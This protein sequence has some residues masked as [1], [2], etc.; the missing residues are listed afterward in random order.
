MS[1]LLVNLGR[2]L[3]RL[4][5]GAAPSLKLWSASDL[6]WAQARL[7]TLATLSP[8]GTRDCRE[9]RDRTPSW[10][11]TEIGGK[12]S[13]LLSFTFCHRLEENARANVGLLACDGI[14]SAG[15]ERTYQLKVITIARFLPGTTLDGSGE[16]IVFFM[17]CPGSEFY[18]ITLSDTN[19]K[20]I[21]QKSIRF[22]LAL[23]DVDIAFE[24]RLFLKNRQLVLWS[25]KMITPRHHWRFRGRSSTLCRQAT[26]ASTK[27]RGQQE[28]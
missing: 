14:G 25:Q 17:N 7:A 19:D 28:E 24:H 9:K 1:R 23:I 16:A 21:T 15:F 18:V 22:V 13:I 26:R 4:R 8:K 10:E 27:Q 5:L 11:G 20:G 12:G 6:R 2:P 3:T